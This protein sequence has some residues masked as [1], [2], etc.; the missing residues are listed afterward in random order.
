MIREIINTPKPRYGRF[1]LSTE[2]PG[3]EKTDTTEDDS[4]SVI[5]SNTKVIT[6]KPNNRNRIDFTDGADVLPEDDEPVDDTADTAT[7]T[8]D[9][10]LSTPEMD[11]PEFQSPDGATDDEPVVTDNDY[12]ADTT[13]DATTPD[14]TLDDGTVDPNATSQPDATGDANVTVTDPDNP[15]ANNADTSDLDLDGDNVDFTSDATDDG[16]GDVDAEQPADDGTQQPKGPG[17]EYDSTR[18]YK[19]FQNYISLI[20]AIDNYVAKLES[21]MSDNYDSNRVFRDSVTKLQ[22][23]RDLAMDYT[24]M[25]FEIATYVQSLLFYENLIVMIQ[26][27]FDFISKSYQAITKNDKNNINN[28]K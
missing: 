6:V 1:F 3:D 7:N 20:N 10:D 19:L 12:Q 13:A 14:A 16:T 23:I 2:A 18:K 21:Y 9:L 25:K 5:K 15:D 27:V 24:T 22:E 11:G 17:L 4:S 26:L 28:K 8:G